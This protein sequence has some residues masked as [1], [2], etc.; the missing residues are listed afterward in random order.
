MCSNMF[1]SV[2]FQK[3]IQGESAQEP[4]T[5]WDEE[6]CDV[7]HPFQEATDVQ[8]EGEAE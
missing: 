1:F 5:G 2:L 3:V 8:E 4:S 6:A 7:L